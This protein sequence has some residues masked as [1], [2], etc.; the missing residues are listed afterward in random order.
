MKN[1]KSDAGLKMIHQYEVLHVFQVFSV[2][3]FAFLIAATAIC[4][5]TA[6]RTQLHIEIDTSTGSFTATSLLQD[7]IGNIALPQAE[8][9]TIDE[10]SLQGTDVPTEDLSSTMIDASLHQ[11][12]DLRM[13]VSGVFPEPEGSFVSSASSLDATYSIG[14]VLFPVDAMAIRDH[15]VTVVVPDPQRVAGTGRLMRVPRED[16]FEEARLRFTGRSDDFGLFVGPYVTETAEHS[17]VRLRTYFYEADADLSERYF[18]A[19][20]TFISRFEAEIGAYPYDEFS[21]VATSMPVGLGFAGL[22]YISRDILSH[23]YMTGRSLAHEILHSWWGNAV[24]IAYESGNWSEGLTTFQADYGLAEDQGPDAARAM[25]VGWIRALAQLAEDQREPLTAFRSSTHNGSQV[26]GYGKAA[27]VFHMLRYELGSTAFRDSVQGFYA[28]NRNAVASW[29]DLQAAFEAASGKDLAWFFD[30]WINRAGMPDL[31]FQ[32]GD[33][34]KR[35]DG[36]Y[37]A[38]LELTQTAPAYRLSVPVMVETA[39]GPIKRRVN[40]SELS[41]D[42]VITLPA[43]PISVQLDPDFDLVRHP[44]NGELAPTLRSIGGKTVGAL[45][46]ATSNGE[47]AIASALEPILRGGS[48]TWLDDLDVAHDGPKLVAGSAD[49][50][51]ALRP[52]I[53]GAMPEEVGQ[54]ATSLWIERDETGQL[55][56]FLSFDAIDTL[57]EDLRLLGFYAAQSFIHV[58]N[59]AVSQSGIWSDESARMKM[60]FDQAN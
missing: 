12:R 45:L 44:L 31:R 32:A 23:D 20:G 19:S 3:V 57:S 17:S 24:G 41:Q 8:W 1:R 13:S 10:L 51:A 11:N 47:D 34:T 50:L 59:G 46:S 54:N 35:E 58:S 42:A 18:V 40:I 43:E 21:V 56:L 15:D 36:T 30:Q 7:P 38:V 26:E 9:L 33:V 22:T 53:L 55:W 2:A 60:L 39:S 49:A 14:P 29:A 5:D 37:Q 52:D 6:P 25:R 28:A 4:A 27:M 48:V 16:G